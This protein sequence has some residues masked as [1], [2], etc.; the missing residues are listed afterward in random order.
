ELDVRSFYNLAAQLW[1]EQDLLSDSTLDA[2]VSAGIRK[3]RQRSRILQF[4]MKLRPEF[5][6]TRSQLISANTTKVD[7]I[8]GDL[9][10]AETR[11]K[12]QAKLDGNSV[13]GSVFA[14]TY[15]GSGGRP[16]FTF[17]S[18]VNSSSNSQVVVPSSG[19]SESRCHHCNEPG[20]FRNHCRNRNFCTYCKKSGHIILDC[21]R[22]SGRRGANVG[23]SDRSS[24]SR[25]TFYAQSFTAE[26]PSAA[27]DDRITQ[28][29]QAALQQALPTALQACFSAF[30]VSGDQKTRT[31]IGKGH[32]DGRTFYLDQLGATSI[33]GA[34]T[35]SVQSGARQ[36]WDLWHSR[37]GHPHSARLQLMFRNKLLPMSDS[38]KNII[39]LDESCVHCIGAKAHKIPFQSGFSSDMDIFDL[40]HSDLWGPSPVTSRLGY[41][42]FALF[43]DHAS[44][45]TWIYPLR[46]KSELIRVTQAF[47][48]MIQTQFHKTI[49]RLQSDPGGEYNSNDLRAFYQSHGI[50]YQQSCLGVSEQNGVVERKNRHVLELARAI[51]LQTNVPSTFWPEV[52]STV[53]YLI[54]RQPSA[55]L[56]HVSPYMK[57]FGKSPQYSFLRTFGCVCYV[58]LPRTERTKLTSKAAKCVFVGYSE[59]HKGYL[60]YDPIQRRVRIAYHVIFMERI[61]YYSSSSSSSST[62]ASSRMVPAYDPFSVSIDEGPTAPLDSDPPDLGSSGSSSTSSSSNSSTSSTADSNPAKALSN[63]SSSSSLASTSL[64]DP[65]PRRSYHS[66]LGQTPSHLNDFVIYATGQSSIPIPRN[67]KEASLDPNWCRAMDDES[68]ALDV[69]NTWSIVP[70][71]P[72]PKRVLGSKWVFTVKTHPDGTLDRYKAR[73]VAQGFRQEYGID[74]EETFA[75]VAKMQT[76]RTLLA[77]AS[78]RNWPL[79]QLDVKNAFLHGDLHETVYLECPPGYNK[80]GSDVVCRLHRSLYGLKQ[81]PR[82]WF[83]KFQSTIA[84]TGFHQS[85]SDPSLFLKKSATGI[86]VLLIYV[87]DMILTGDDMDE[88]ARTKQALQEH[89]HL[90]ELG[91]LSYF[92]GLEIQRSPKGIFVNQKKYIVD[93]LADAGC[94][95]CSPCSTPMEMN[96]KLSKDE[97]EALSDPTFYR[98]LVGSLIYLV[99]TRPDVA[100]AVQV[101]SQFMSLP[102]K[103]HLNAVYRILRYLQG[104]HSLGIYL[105]SSRTSELRAYADADYAGCVDTRRSTS[106]WCVKVGNSC[107][108]WRCKKQDR[109]SKS[110]TEAEYRSM[111]E[112]CSEIVWLRRLL[113]EL[114]SVVDGPAQLY[115]DNTSAIQIASNPVLHDRTKHIETHVHYIRELIQ[116][117]EIGVNYLHTDDQIA[118][119]FTKAVPTSRHWYLTDKLM[120]RDQHQFEGGC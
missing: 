43:I 97:G 54:N 73:L 48:L 118:D 88:I 72:P 86:T 15:R 85:Q 92:L 93:L 41:R 114:G 98:R 6:S 35:F 16:Q 51:L 108:A 68:A 67:Y 63:T 77:V 99:S 22:A 79:L 36:I 13:E 65:P 19:K 71:P 104:T 119:I 12:T 9:V 3:E 103:P 31:R 44:R 1:T 69:N 74:Y 45:Y 81:A 46:L 75:P 11:L 24:I 30:G 107:V 23:G 39:P 109:V 106:G 8:L 102:R 83:E 49:K 33:P 116:A 66:N 34:S 76:V 40:V 25:P 87:D 105:P 5:E 94:A 89:F 7:T 59:H 32:K 60:C 47:V 42:Y 82:A 91:H 61:F 20:H 110:S 84:N 70:R 38:M 111:S 96:L 64:A 95:E 101:V 55:T 56:G 10:R 50:L 90:K 2:D 14:A 80:T 112:V 53:T 37:L 21:S 26:S 78:Q 27:S 100:Y 62:P 117:K 28:L 113:E 52:V 115:A 18:Q 57:L 17:P 4:L 120:C 58:L 29:V